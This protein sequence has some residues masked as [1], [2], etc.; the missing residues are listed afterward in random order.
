MGYCRRS[1]T[2]LLGWSGD[3]PSQF[4][5]E[6]RLWL[7]RFDTP[8]G[9]IWKGTWRQCTHVEFYVQQAYMQHS[10]QCSISP[11]EPQT[12]ALWSGT[13]CSTNWATTAVYFERLFVTLVIKLRNL[14]IECNF[15]HKSLGLFINF[16][17]PFIF[18]FESCR[19]L[20]VTFKMILYMLN[21]VQF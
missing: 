1:R 9:I 17:S 15:Y 20:E 2:H 14:N 12:Q 3:M 7:P 8:R 6:R 5:S 18:L 13:Q 16:Y 21:E 10:V 4:W 11:G 19:L